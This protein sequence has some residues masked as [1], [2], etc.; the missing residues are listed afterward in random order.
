VPYTNN[1][2][3]VTDQLYVNNVT[4]S[5]LVVEEALAAFIGEDPNGEWLLTISDDA[6][7]DGGALNGWALEVTGLRAVPT[8]LGGGGSNTTPVS[9][10][11]T[12]TPVV[13]STL[14]LSGLPTFLTDLNFSTAISH[15][16]PGDLDMT[17]RSPQGTIVT[18]STD[19]GSTNDN[20]FAGTVWDDDANPGGQVPYTNNNG[21]VTDHLYVINVIA[22]PL[23]PEEAFGAFI[24]EDP[25]GEWLLTIADD[26]NADGGSLNQ[27]SLEVTTGTC[28]PPTSVRLSTMESAPAAIP[29]AGWLL[30]ALIV[31]GLGVGLVLRRRLAG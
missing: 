18:F 20:V 24:G 7:N 3:M 21:L 31:A 10:T 13:T 9:I 6:T 23:V 17:L 2:G 14:T 29:V 8:S 26:A 15:T 19:N 4:A 16:F 1:N 12:G 25:N 27:W 28:G 22:S 11:A 5:P 30:V